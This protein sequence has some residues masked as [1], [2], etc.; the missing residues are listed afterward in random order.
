MAPEYEHTFFRRIYPGKRL[1]RLLLS[2]EMGNQL[3]LLGKQKAVVYMNT[4]EGFRPLTGKVAD[5]RFRKDGRVCVTGTGWVEFVKEIR[6]WH[7]DAIRV[8]YGLSGETPLTCLIFLDSV[9]RLS[10]QPYEELSDDEQ[11]SAA[12]SCYVT[13]DEG[14]EFPSENISE[15]EAE[16]P[17]HRRMSPGK[18]LRRLLLSRES[19]DRLRLL[20]KKKAFVYMNTNEGIRPWPPKFA[21]VVIRRDGRVCLTGEGWIYFVQKMQLWH[22]EMVKVA[23]FPGRN[24]EIGVFV[25]EKLKP[26]YDRQNEV[27]SE[28]ESDYESEYLNSLED[29]SQS[30]PN[31][32]SHDEYASWPNGTF[33]EALGKE[34]LLIEDQTKVFSYT[35]GEDD[36][37]PYFDKK[38]RPANMVRTYI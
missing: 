14:S 35:N 27:L 15:E 12:D 21:D 20:G 37:P 6:L 26:H 36:D 25:M 29:L 5:I 16:K 38:F 33:H 4:F 11:S 22:N 24:K 9:M 2:R 34:S 7:Y 10:K 28:D 19:G 18:S 17:F 8:D 31:I 13:L 3:R 32:H 30:E 1:A 23:Y